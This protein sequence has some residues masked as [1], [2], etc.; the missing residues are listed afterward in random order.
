MLLL[1]ESFFVLD[2]QV[3]YIFS[4]SDSTKNNELI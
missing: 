1:V 3:I 2:N 4:W